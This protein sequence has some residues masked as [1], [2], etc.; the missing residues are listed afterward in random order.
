MNLYEYIKS[1]LDNTGVG[2]SGKKITALVCTVSCFVYPI[3]SW[4][5]WAY[6]HNDFSNLT[7]VLT[8]TSGFVCL[9]FGINEYGKKN[10]NEPKDNNDA[11]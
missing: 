10:N 8:I 7:S 1:S 5:Y 9:L 6:H 2:A 11:G 3:V 4:T